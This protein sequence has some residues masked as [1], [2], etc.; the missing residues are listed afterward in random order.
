MASTVLSLALKKAVALFPGAASR[1]HDVDLTSDKMSQIVGSLPRQSA[2]EQYADTQTIAIIPVCKNSRGSLHLTRSEEAAL[3]LLGAAEQRLHS[4][5]FDLQQIQDSFS[6]WEGD[7]KIQAAY[8][9]S[10]DSEFSQLGATTNAGNQ[11]MYVGIIGLLFSFVGG[12][13]MRL[14]RR[15]F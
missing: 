7:S 14:K 11:A 8:T 6:S 5:I 13:M 9:T 1:Y 3:Q 12:M 10:V 4:S 2:D 15:S